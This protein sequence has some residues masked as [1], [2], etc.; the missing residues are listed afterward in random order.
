M[1]RSL[2]LLFFLQLT[3]QDHVRKSDPDPDSDPM[4]L[5]SQMGMWSRP[6]KPNDAP[7]ESAEAPS[8]SV[9][10]ASSNSS[11]GDEQ[12][13]VAGVPMSMDD[14]GASAGREEEKE[15]RTGLGTAAAKSVSPGSRSVGIGAERADTL[16]LVSGSF[17]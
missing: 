14:T 12:M 8:R 17:F 7:P 6:S 3:A 16:L 15:D 11:N 9:P 2:F 4:L 13:A 1:R 10:L 5:A